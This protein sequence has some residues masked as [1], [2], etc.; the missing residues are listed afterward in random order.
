M[1][2]DGFSELLLHSLNESGRIFT[3]LHSQFKYSVLTFTVELRFGVMAS[4][5]GSC[6]IGNRVDC[7]DELLQRSGWKAIRT[8]TENVSRNT[9]D[10]ALFDI[11]WWANSMVRFYHSLTN[12]RSTWPRIAFE[13]RP[14]NSWSFD[15]IYKR[16]S[17]QLE[18]VWNDR[19][20]RLKATLCATKCTPC[21]IWNTDDFQHTETARS[22]QGISWG[23]APVV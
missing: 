11:L 6:R 19:K 1:D 23:R 8:N 5:L 15:F 4:L 12:E 18:S 3:P 10:T 7:E 20:L 21:G 9:I 22:T 17:V 16:I 14:F 2:F 13:V